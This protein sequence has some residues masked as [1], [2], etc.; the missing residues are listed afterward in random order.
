M[1]ERKRN[2][3]KVATWLDDKGRQEY[4]TVLYAMPK[5][6]QCIFTPLDLGRSSTARILAC[7]TA[8]CAKE[9]IDYER[10]AVH[11]QAIL[12]ARSHPEIPI[13]RPEFCTVSFRRNLPPEIFS[14]VLPDIGSEENALKFFKGLIP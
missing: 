2:V 3:V 13:K 5:P 8:I 1:E 10:A 12:S 4:V 7:A 6:K 14:G 11:W 9:H